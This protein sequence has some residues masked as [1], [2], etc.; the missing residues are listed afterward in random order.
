MVVKVSENNHL[1]FSIEYSMPYE[2]KLY[3]DYFS[4]TFWGE[5]NLLGMPPGPN[6]N[7]LSTFWVL[8]L[9]VKWVNEPLTSWFKWWKWFEGE[10]YCIPFVS[11]ISAVLS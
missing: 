4:G 7:W 6:L 3:L 11:V 8:W 9:Y 5:M 10:C 2:D 1:G